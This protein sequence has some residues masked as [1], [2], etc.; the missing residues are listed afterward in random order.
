MR[1]LP[2]KTGKNYFLPDNLRDTV[3]IAV[4]LRDM[5][6]PEGKIQEEKNQIYHDNIL[7]F[8]DYYERQWLFS[9]VSSSEYKRMQGLIHAKA[10]LHEKSAFLLRK[11]YELTEEKNLTV[12]AQFFA[13][14]N[15]NYFIAMGW[16]GTYRANVFAEEAKKYAYAFQVLYTIRLNEILRSK[17]CKELVNFMGG[18]LWAGYFQNILPVV[19]TEQIDRSR[20]ELSTVR[21]FNTIAQ[22]LYP[23]K[24]ILL[25]EYQD[26]QHYATQISKNDTKRKEKI[27]TWT[28]LGML[29]NTWSRNNVYQLFYTYNSSKVVFANHSLL[30]YLHISI[31][32]YIL[33]LCNPECVYEKLNMEY[34]GISKEDFEVVVEEILKSN[35]YVIEI[36]RRFVVNTDVSMELLDYCSK[37]KEIKEGGDKSELERSQAAVDVFFKNAKKFA[38]DYLDMESDD[39]GTLNLAYDDGKEKIQISLIY[40]HLLEAAVQERK[41]DVSTNLN[42]KK[43][44]EM[45]KAFNDKLTTL[46]ERVPEL[47]SVSKY[48]ITKTA[49][50]AEA[51]MSSL[52]SNIQRYYSLHRDEKISDTDVLELCDLYGNIM[53]IYWKN[54]QHIISEKLLGKYKLLR[55]RFDKVCQE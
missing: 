9:N 49:K 23:D 29:S 51:N 53:S 54:P 24:G 14:T 46:A 39:M 21:A 16:L 18:Y 7:R 35:A 36:Y 30:Q 5:K 47:E 31:E 33:S 4:L 44:N 19:Q 26:K 8:F 55:N 11:R 17:K 27:I 28:L 20:F 34:L 3:N 25:P 38:K 50:N 6:D 41:P 12:L 32:N 48:L 40:A 37:R 43:R 15:D 13:E 2:D 10:Q 1:F 45:I 42:E 52:A 22:A